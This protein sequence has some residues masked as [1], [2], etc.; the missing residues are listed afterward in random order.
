MS[1]KYKLP[2]QILNFFADNKIEIKQ[3][4]EEF[5]S[6]PKDKYF[7]ELVYCLCT[8]MSKAENAFKVQKIFEDIDF[9]NNPVDPNQILRNPQNYIRFHN[10]KS[11]YIIQNHKNFSKILDVL[12]N[13]LNPY[14]KRNELIKVTMG[15][16]MKEAS[17]FLRN[18]GQFGLAILDRHIIRS[19]HRLGFLNEPPKNLNKKNYLI[20]ERFYIEVCNY[21]K[22]SVEELDLVLWKIETGK[23]LK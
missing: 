6:I 17:H 4:L 13:E 19:L 9:F 20:L 11:K 10:Q 12:K 5:K 8:P 16:G 3:K 15:L 2:K 22:L 14:E 21:N 7:Y 23:I 18:I 1:K